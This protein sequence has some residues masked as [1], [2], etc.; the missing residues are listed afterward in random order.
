MFNSEPFIAFGLWLFHV[1]ANRNLAFFSP[2]GSC[3]LT[4]LALWHIIHGLP[5]RVTAVMLADT[6]E[7]YRDHEKCLISEFKRIF[8]SGFP[9]SIL[10]QL[11]DSIVNWVERVPRRRFGKILNGDIVLC[12]HIA[13]QTGILLDPIYTLAAWEHSVLLSLEA[14]KDSDIVMLHTGG[15]LGLFGIAQRRPEEFLYAG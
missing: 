4:K 9:D 7:W 14:E 13:K 2:Q 15:T 5:W 3:Q 6:L 12:R 11:G 1:I 10:D 8:L